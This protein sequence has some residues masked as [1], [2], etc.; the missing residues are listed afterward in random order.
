[1]SDA[2]AQALAQACADAMWAEDRASRDLGMVREAVGPG[3]A[4]LA[5]RVTEAMVN[6]LGLCHGGLIFTLADS[7]MAFACNSRGEQAVAQQGAITYLRPARL[8]DVL[9]A[10]ATERA[11]EGR[12]AMYDVRVTT[13]DGAVVAEMRG[14]TRTLGRKFFEAGA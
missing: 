14:H 4:R 1:M 6:G 13:R 2:T 3:H 11:S 7:A 8:G 5:M 10:A 9:T 12:T